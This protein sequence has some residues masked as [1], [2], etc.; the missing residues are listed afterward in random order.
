M[1]FK[2]K[3]P[4]K[5]SVQIPGYL[6]TAP[7]LARPANGNH[8]GGLHKLQHFVPYFKYLGLLKI[9]IL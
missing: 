1:H 6:P 7:K 9:T 4:K 5:H 2:K 3:L 8:G